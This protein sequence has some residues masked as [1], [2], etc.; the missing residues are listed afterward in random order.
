MPGDLEIDGDGYAA[1][2]GGNLAARSRSNDVHQ[3]AELW[4]KRESGSSPKI[5]QRICQDK[6]KKTARQS[7][8]E[9][10]ALFVSTH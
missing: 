9:I 3:D 1:I 4:K 2:V 8:I 10:V 5:L 7:K 6:R